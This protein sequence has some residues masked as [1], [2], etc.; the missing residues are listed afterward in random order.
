MKKFVAF[1][2]ERSLLINIVSLAILIAG[3]MF[4]F[5]ANREAFPKVDF[6]W[7]I[8]KT[9]YPGATAE[10]VEKH[11][12]I[13]IET[14]L[15]EVDD[16]DELYTTSTE[17][18]SIT[19]VKLDPDVEDKDNVINDIKN[20]IDLIK[21]FPDD[22][23]DPEVIE[24]K[25]SQRP[26][27]EV[28]IIDKNGIR[29]DDDERE[30]RKHA[31]MLED[32]LLEIDGI[33]KVE[34]S[35]Y[36]ERE[37]IVE[38]DP[39]LL[40]NYHVAINDVI[41]ALSRKNLN[42]PG[43]LV[44]T[45]TEE[46]MV[47]TIGE[48]ENVKDIENVL[49]RA[50][51]LGN[52][53]RVKD[54][55][56]VKD[57]FEEETIINKT[58]GKKSITLT[59]IKKQS[60]D[61]IDVVD[62]VF[63]IVNKFNTRFS[64]RYEF[65]TSRDLSYFV[66][67]R[68]RVLKNNAV[69]GSILVLLSLFITLGWRISI[70]T[71]IGLPLA[72]CMTFIWM[73]QQQ[74]TV[75]LISMFGLIVVLGMLVD[76]A[77]IVAENV[78]RHLEEGKSA[79]DAVI[80]GTSEVIIPVAGTILT[81][82]AAFSPLMF[83]TGIMGK[84]M[85]ALPAV[86]SVSLVGSW[87][88]S[89]FIL[90][91]HILDIEKRNKKSVKVDEGGKLFFR[92]RD[93]YVKML[94]FVLNNRY[95]FALLIFLIF[96]G[97]VIFAR[98]HVKF[99]LFPQ[100]QI[101]RF[102]VVTQGKN[103]TSVQEMNRKLTKIEKFIA[104]L[105][106]EEME[107]FITKAG[108]IQYQS[109]G[110]KEKT[111]SNYGSI[112]VYLTPEQE[113]KRT[114]DEIM[115]ALREETKPLHGE[116]EKI[117]FTYIKTGPPVGAAVNVTIKGDDF[118]TLKK[119]AQEYKDY[120][121]KIPGLKDIEDNFEEGKKE[122]KIIVNEKLA[123]IAGISV[124]DVASTVRSSLKGTVATKIK[125]TDEEINIRVIF[126]ERL[127]SNLKDIN[128]IKRNFKLIKISNRIGNLIPL[129]R[130]ARFEEST[131]LSVISRR[132]RKRSV[133]VTANIDEKAKKLSSVYINSL[134]SRDF[135]NIDKR[136]PGILVDYLGEFKDTKESMINLFKSFIIAFLLIY[137]ILV[138]LFRSL[139]HPVIIM[140]VIPLA[141]VGVVW[142]FYIHGL[143][144][145][146]LAIMGVVGLTGVVVNDS[147]VFVDFIKKGRA[148]GLTPFDATVR[149]GGHRLRAIFLTTITTF[150]GLVPTAYGIGGL[151]PFLVPM[152]TSMAWGIIFGTLITL[153]ATP[154]LYMIF[155]DLRK[156]VY[157]SVKSAESF[158]AASYEE[159]DE[160]ESMKKKLEEEIKHDIEEEIKKDISKQIK[161]ELTSE[162]KSKK[163][164]KKRSG[165]KKKKDE[166]K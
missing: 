5:K 38:V 129:S 88:E 60:G 4:L 101:E 162:I 39:V 52:W 159:K 153:F 111:G 18:L 61:I 145:S 131:S 27:L 106:R 150:L 76:D 23:E 58:E 67:R 105:P 146:F 84:F 102:E 44:K 48:V 143:P 64:K 11:I 53:V 135:K 94:N 141:F 139:M 110:Q 95:K 29:N 25:T 133:R 115:D 151:D 46:V 42:H 86:V 154:M 81:T 103:G 63:S 96:A 56:R 158:A 13:P 20:A 85:W 128:E 152:A 109:M 31:K 140:S 69:V 59:V 41:L 15:H 71:A 32:R 93:R 134:L 57:S 119:V 112:I 138:A 22:A 107:T 99:I 51:D 54:V 100:G 90:P 78:Y 21:D 117:E 75:N 114:A 92:I 121:K 144:L 55:A 28:S 155:T 98:T 2:A 122:L 9:L 123:S 45:D 65:I 163:S 130:I 50:N 70:V 19:A 47:R 72:F 113:R 149:A 147:I 1:F 14:Q 73:G 79:R 3:I 108:V 68:L 24:L 35:G 6:D 157:K 104:R 132:D 36:R 8:I 120:L 125:K 91:S 34:R 137:V 43:G 165:V 37:M 116:F 62:E 7:V 77:I 124:F 82:I 80:D 148:E 142:V 40:E 160:I 164:G 74:L 30:L 87:I 126:P 66:K 49:I 12:S 161:E 16:I 89:M 156:F 26:I 33:A 136:Y 166:I 118:A 10:D 17:S 97:T 127:R 83:M